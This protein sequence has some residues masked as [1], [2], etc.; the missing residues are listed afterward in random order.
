MRK[1]PR[2][3]Y[4]RS[5]MKSKVKVKRDTRQF[6]NQAWIRN[7][8]SDAVVTGEALILA[9][10]LHSTGRDRAGDDLKVVQTLMNDVNLNDKE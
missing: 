6:I 8:K 5:I 1:Q 7:G 3:C 2:F 4:P 9:C 10:L